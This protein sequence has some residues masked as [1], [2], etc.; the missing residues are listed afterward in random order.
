[1]KYKFKSPKL[2]PKWFGPY[3]VKRGFPSGYVELFDKQGGSFIVNGHR[4]KLYYD[5][6]QM[7]EISIKEIPLESE[8][9]SITFLTPFPTD[10]KEK[11]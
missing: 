3:I 2:K 11:F 6:E 4:I 9:E 1:M 7:N 8:Y 10:Y 5:K